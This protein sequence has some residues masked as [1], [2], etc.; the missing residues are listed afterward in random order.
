MKLRLQPLLI[1]PILLLA[2]FFRVFDT[3]WD[4]G[5]H[6]HPDERFLT[7]VGVAIHTP[8]QLSDY[9]YQGVSTLNPANV[10]F[11]FFVYGT[12]PLLLTWGI[13]TLTDHA[14]YETLYLVGRYLSAASD[15]LVVLLIYKM[16]SLL[17]KKD[18]LPRNSKFWASL[19]YAVAVLPTQLSHF[20][21]VDMFL[22]FFLIA[23]I[24]TALAYHVKHRLRYIVATGVFFGLSL[25]AKISAVYF[26]P[27]IIYL[28]LPLHASLIRIRSEGRIF[29]HAL[30][31]SA[32]AM[33]H[34]FGVLLVFGL[35]AYLVLRM[36][37]PYIFQNPIFLDPRP[38][39]QFVKNLQELKSLG[40]R[41][42][43]FPPNVQWI[44][45]IPVLFALK[46]IALWGLGIPA[47]LLAA[48][49]FVF[50]IRRRRTS[51][52]FP[53]MLWGIIYFIYQSTQTAQTMRYFLPLYPLLAI[54]AALGVGM[55][56]KRYKAPL[57]WGIVCI[58]ILLP[59]AFFFSIYT[60]PHTRVTA[61]HWITTHIPPKSILLS[62]HWDDALPLPI[63]EAA[64]KEYELVQLPVF[65]PDTPEKWTQM[66]SLLK[67]G[68]YLIL[69][70]NRGWGSIPTAP[71]RYP[72]MTQFY[73]DLFA[74]KGEYVF[75]TEFTSYP[76]L[77]YLGIPL[78]IPD[79][80]AEEAFTV[81]DHPRVMIFKKK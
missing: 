5:F 40:D 54:C 27:I 81:Y 70:S 22:Q 51:V 50:I 36:A 30:K 38:N 75:V 62:E 46:N 4:S 77:T 20:F 44:N 15:I 3:D 49:G 48:L 59:V 66:D 76:S 11:P 57:V 29:Q 61:S 80:T 60:K 17:E 32:S 53:M 72:R 9:F 8:A 28:L 42:G 68:D 65:D 21:A 10:G 41:S 33:L 47:S 19:I 74:D 39:E 25:A 78:T 45:K 63:P 71:E 13:G 52:L 73:H 67:S 14:T 26:L 6:L 37:D 69:S 16:L 12:F 7:M 18:R 23:G 79:D 43:W 2:G 24:Y 55:I 64:T 35:T 58:S 34:L 1:I 31:T 56:L